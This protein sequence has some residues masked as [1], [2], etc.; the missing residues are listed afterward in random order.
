MMQM[1]DEIAHVGV[2][3]CRMRFRF[4]CGEGAVIVGID[5]DNVEFGR[6]SE[7]DAVER[8]EFPAKDEMQKLF[9]FFCGRHE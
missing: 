5:A 9:F 2:I 6:I 1:N 7:S 8:G 3:D 4:P